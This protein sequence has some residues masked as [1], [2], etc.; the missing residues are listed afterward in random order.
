MI[1]SVVAQGRVQS[2]QDPHRVEAAMRQ[3]EKYSAGNPS[4]STV[5]LFRKVNDPAVLLLLA[6]WDSGAGVAVGPEDVAST[7]AFD[8]LC[9]GTIE[10]WMFRRRSIHESL[11]RPT[12][13]D[14]ALVLAPTAARNVVQTVSEQVLAPAVNALPGFVLRC[15][16][17]DVQNPDRLLTLQGWDSPAALQS[18]LQEMAPR[19]TTSLCRLGATVDRFVGYTR[20]GLAD[21]PVFAAATPSGGQREALIPRWG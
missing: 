13:F 12:A 7:P 18:F 10:H 9:V 1:I 20:G 4:R 14:C 17:Q 8:A 19:L 2:G 16:Y 3:L 21:D 15:T 6:D 5:R 11:C